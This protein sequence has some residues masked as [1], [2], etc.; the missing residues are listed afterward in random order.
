M[1]R[2]GWLIV[3]SLIVALGHVTP[4]YA[5]ERPKNR[6]LFVTPIREYV[7]VRAGTT[8]DGS[9]TV[10]NITEKP[11][12]VTLS[13]EQFSV[14]DYTYDYT[15]SSVKEDW[16]KLGTTQLQLQPNKSQLINYTVDAPK[17]AAPG[18]HYFTLFASASLGDGAV[19]SKVRA[20][21][22]LYVTVAGELKETSEIKKET[23]PWISF[24]NDIDFTL[25]VKNTGNTHF[26]VYT[27]GKVNA[28]TAKPDSTEVTHILLPDTTRTVG[29]TIAAPILPGL[30]TVTYGYKTEDG[31]TVNRSK[32]IV[33]IP[34]WSLAIP[35][36][37]GW[38]VWLVRK[39]SRHAGKSPTDS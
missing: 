13:V 35:L 18:G 3:L 6:G 4:S 15:F 1:K 29:S 38:I 28:W 22:V 9:L 25:D 2:A 21:T 12:T 8:K 36:G 34:P 33:T 17:N 24:G 5:D 30:Y 14:A 7:K 31:H 20:A 39:R 26:F 11:V 32:M 27:S 23:I 19:E 10:A 37:V 16:I